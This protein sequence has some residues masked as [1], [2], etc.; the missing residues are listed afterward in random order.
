[1][2]D[3]RIAIILY[4]G[5]DELDAIGPYEVFRHAAKMGAD[6]AVSMVT[7]D[8]ADEVAASGGLRVRPDGKLE[9]RPDM[10]VIPGGGWS[11][12]AERGAWGEAQR[13]EI[14]RLLNQLHGQGTIVATVCTGGM[15]AAA[16][17]LTKGR[18]AI[19]HR[20]AL[21]DLRASGAEVIESR[22]VDSGDLVMAGGV[23]SGIDLA[24]WI[25][26]R[27]FGAGIA[28][29]VTEEMEYPRSRDV[30]RREPQPA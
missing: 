10:V 17:G 30:W 13:G 20:S 6:I 21:D 26:E 28:D 2:R 18:P 9:G 15:L 29:T 14:P 3:V 16:A 8:G 7:L 4:E 12:R 24:L 1:M 11:N 27:E 25:V 23:T 5:F 19:T 22:V